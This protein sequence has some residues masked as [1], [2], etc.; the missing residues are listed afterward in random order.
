VEYIPT[1][2]YQHWLVRDEKALS[3]VSKVALQAS[4]QTQSNH[5]EI[6]TKRAVAP[7]VSQRGDHRSELNFLDLTS[8]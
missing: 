2:T 7:Q 3:I 6:H 5:K 8:P 4:K 1:N